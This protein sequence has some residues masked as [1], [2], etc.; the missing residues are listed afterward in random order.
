MLQWRQVK[1][2]VV[3]EILFFMHLLFDEVIFFRFF[4]GLFA[5]THTHKSTQHRHSSADAAFLEGRQWHSSNMRGD[6]TTMKQGGENCQCFLFNNAFNFM[7]RWRAC[8]VCC[9]VSISVL[10]NMWCSSN[11][12]LII[13]LCERVSYI[14]PETQNRHAGCVAS[15]ILRKNP[16]EKETGC[17]IAWGSHSDFNRLEVVDWFGEFRRMT[18]WV[19]FRKGNHRCLNCEESGVTQMDWKFLDVFCHS[20]SVSL[21]TFF[22]KNKDQTGRKFSK[23]LFLQGAIYVA[24]TVKKLGTK[25][26]SSLGPGISAFCFN[27][28]VFT[29]KTLACFWM[30][31]WGYENASKCI[32][33]NFSGLQQRGITLI[34]TSCRNCVAQ[35]SGLVCDDSCVS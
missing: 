20:W 15:S 33:V 18:K 23:I 27:L 8:K 25:H 28:V 3:W 4:P 13:P 34:P 30:N 12:P 10:T 9:F 31:G 16:V 24:I 29:S 5:H 22:L 21:K 35:T 19:W 14:Q 1:T 32:H 2:T 7:I 11:V 17:E 26:V 6:E